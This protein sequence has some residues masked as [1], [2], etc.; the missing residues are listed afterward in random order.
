MPSS[1][2]N[3]EIVVNGMSAS[4][5][6]SKW[7]NS[8]IVVEV[9]PEDVPEEFIHEAE[10]IGSRELS[11]LLFRKYLEKKAGKHGVN[12]MAPSQRMKDF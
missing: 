12:Q 2:C 9:Y 4:A 1:S 6:N 11:S 7:S 3:G 10:Q 5:R 8:A